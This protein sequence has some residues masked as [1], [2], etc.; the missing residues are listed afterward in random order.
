[1]ENNIYSERICGQC[2]EKLCDFYKFRQLIE[3]SNKVIRNLHNEKLQFQS[4]NLENKSHALAINNTAINDRTVDRIEDSNE[5]PLCPSVD[6]IHDC[7]NKGIFVFNS[8]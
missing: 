6:E 3:Y 5:Q 1:M 7:A 2:V 8:E 4:A